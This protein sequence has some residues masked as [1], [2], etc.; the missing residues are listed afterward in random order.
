MFTRSAAVS[1]SGT[2]QVLSSS[3]NPACQKKPS[4]PYADIS[5]STEKKQQAYMTRL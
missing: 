5:L 1:S 4:K 3:D 2:D